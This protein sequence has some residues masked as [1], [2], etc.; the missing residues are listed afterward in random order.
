M[1]IQPIASWIKHI[2][3]GYLKV[4]SIFFPK[5]LF[6]ELV[7][8]VISEIYNLDLSFEHESTSKYCNF[9]N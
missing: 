3:A 1:R 6:K 4:S 7:E 5:I 8:L 9:C 2:V